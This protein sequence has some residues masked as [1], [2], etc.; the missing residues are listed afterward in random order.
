MTDLSPAACL[1]RRI[2]QA[3]GELAAYLDGPEA[4]PARDNQARRAVAAMREAAAAAPE[5]WQLPA[6]PADWLESDPAA[7]WTVMMRD[8]SVLE[9]RAY[10]SAR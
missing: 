10:P 5:Q 7:G 3:D 1:R 6:R 4:E 9:V 2:R 8:G